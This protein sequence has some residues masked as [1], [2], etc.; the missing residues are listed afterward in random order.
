MPLAL[1]GEWL[2][3]I[4]LEVFSIQNNSVVVFWMVES[5]LETPQGTQI[6][7]SLTTASQKVG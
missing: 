1:L 3:S 4:I 5:M 2:D 7:W 6:D